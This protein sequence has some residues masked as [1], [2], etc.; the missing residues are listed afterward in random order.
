MRRISFLFSLFVLSL[1]CVCPFA[2]AEGL[3]N[4]LVILSDDQSY[5]HV[6][7]YG[8]PNAK[9]P[10]LDKFASE[11][12]KF[13][14]AYVTS[15]HCV[16]SRASIFTGRS[17]IRTNMTRFTMALP[18]DVITFPEY[19]RDEKGYYIGVT[20]RTHHMNGPGGPE[21]DL[22][23]EIRAIHDKHKL[24][25]FDSR[26]D[27]ARGTGGTRGNPFNNSC[28]RNFAEFLDRVPKGK[29]FYM[30]LCFTEPHR[31]FDGLDIPDPS[32]PAKLVLPSWM[33]DTP[34]VREDL[35]GYYD[36]IS[37]LDH[38]FGRAMDELD[39]RSLKENTIVMFMGDNGAAL[40]RGKGTLYELAINVPLIVRWPGKIAPGSQSDELI[41]GEDIGPTSLAAA[42]IATPSDWTG[43]SFLPILLGEENPPVRQY[44]FAQRGAHGASLPGLST[45]FDLSRA[46][47]GKRHK[48]IFNATFSLPYKPIDILGLP[49][50]KSTQ[51]EARA[52]R[53]PP[54]LVPLYTD[55]PRQIIELYDL[56]E[57]PDELRNLAGRPQVADI[58]R[59]LR[60]AISEWMTFERDFLPLPVPQSRR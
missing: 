60:V 48:L 14:R 39:K 30:Q 32:D 8:D 11:G 51:E 38:V 15:P 18:I 47:V 27:Y 42:G 25:N 56:Q 33:P 50:W 12:M 41:S 3:P 19:L 57:D 53:V 45:S 26:M 4:I 10:N 55:Q 54:S 46:I 34:E 9:T 31:P 49:A 36:L 23:R 40:L 20:G 2:M 28:I 43:K 58:E 59:E 6:G 37:R 29:P 22:A 52:G 1:S 35:A 7:C 16:P 24:I 44:I 13:T 21:N 17:P 5:P